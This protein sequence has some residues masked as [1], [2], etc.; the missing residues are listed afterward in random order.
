MNKTRLYIII[1]FLCVMS[2]LLLMFGLFSPAITLYPQYDGALSKLFSLA[3]DGVSH[4]VTYSTLE[5]IRELFVGGN[6]W[7][8]FF[9]LLGSTVFP[10]TRLIL[11]M[12]YWK[13]AVSGKQTSVILGHIDKVNKYCLLDVVIL[14][15]L[16]VSINKLPGSYNARLEWGV[17]LTAG[18]VFL[19]ATIPF[20]LNKGEIII[21]QEKESEI[22]KNIK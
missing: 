16:I 12:F 4:P 20:L 13:Q 18:S 14:S 22:E 7:I 9:I 1:P 19:G 5:S 21:A 17:Y 15:L 10:Y 11:F 6:A 3:L 8:G 2:G